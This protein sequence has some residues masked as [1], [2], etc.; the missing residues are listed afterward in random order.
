MEEG[1]I[2]RRYARAFAET[3]DEAKQQDKLQTVEGE[4][5]ALKALMEDKSS[6]LRQIMFDPAFSLTERQA[7]MAD[8]CKANSFFSTTTSFLDFLVRQDRVRFIAAIA[9]AFTVEV[10]ARTAQVRAHIVSAKPLDSTMQQKIVAALEKRTGKKVIADVEVDKSVLGGVRASIGGLVF[11]GTI[12]AQLDR[13][14]T[15]LAA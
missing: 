2:G 13:L 9:D 14:Q 15:E 4:L 12:R 6:E 7:V 8:L 1:T 5:R 10:D 11:D 3:L